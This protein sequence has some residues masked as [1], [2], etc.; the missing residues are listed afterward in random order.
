MTWRWKSPASGCDSAPSGRRTGRATRT[1]L[2]A[3]P[4]WGKAATFRAGGIPV[5]GGTTAAGLRRLDLLLAA[6]DVERLVYLGDFLHARA[7][8]TAAVFDALAAWRARHAQID[9]VLVRGNHDRGAGDP[10]AALGTR[11]VDAPLHAAPFALAHHP[12]ASDD[13]YVLAGHLHPGVVLVGAGRERER[14]PC[15]WFGRR[16][17]VLPAF[18]EFTGLATVRP[19]PGDRVVV[20]AGEELLEAR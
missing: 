12:E 11:C 15:F 10:P 14:L 3:D 19:D 8:R 1:L 6:F 5:P 7:G 16:V 17:G 9:V 18:G 4:H 13:G 2:V 20:V